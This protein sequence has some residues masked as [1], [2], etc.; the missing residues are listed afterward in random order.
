MSEKDKT[1]KAEYPLNSRGLGYRSTLEGGPYFKEDVNYLEPLA[2]DHYGYNLCGSCAFYN[3]GRC[4]ALEENVHILG[5]SDLYISMA[6][7]LDL[8]YQQFVLQSQSSF[9]SEEP[10]PEPGGTV[11]I[12]EDENSTQL[13]VK[14]ASMDE[15][16][17]LVYGVV[18]EA[19]EVDYHEDTITAA[20][21]EKAA[22]KFMRTPMVIGDGHVKKAKAFPVESFIYSPEV[23]KDVKEG[24]WVMAIKVQSDSIW[25]GIKSGDYTGLSIGAMVKRTELEDTKDV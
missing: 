23:L 1:V 21:V 17:R 19:D 7:E 15:E 9:K 14:F 2:E 8:R 16:K 12:E 24:S 11:K 3:G 6:H 22:H 5:T 4:E 13:E 20:E 18:L 25:E 10:E